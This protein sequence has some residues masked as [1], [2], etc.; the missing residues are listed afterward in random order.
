MFSK[1]QI[2][3]RIGHKEDEVGGLLKILKVSPKSLLVTEVIFSPIFGQRI[4][5]IMQRNVLQISESDRP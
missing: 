4:F 5:R 1:G 3:L 2:V